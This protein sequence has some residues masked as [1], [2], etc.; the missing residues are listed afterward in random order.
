MRV[1]IVASGE[2]YQQAAAFSA[3]TYLTKSPNAEVSVLVPEE[4]PISN[5]LNQCSE[6]NH[7]DLERFPFRQIS[8]RKFTSQLKCQAFVHALSTAFKGELLAFVDADTCCLKEIRVPR[9]AAQR[10]KDGS[11]AMVPDIK[12]RHF[13]CPNDPWYLAENERRA[14][15]NSGV[16]LATAASLPLFRR[17]RSLSEQSRFLHGPFND[18]KVINFALG[19]YFRDR[20]VMLE[21]KYNFIGPPFSTA[22]IIA[23]FAGGAG[24]L[25]E[26]RRKFLHESFCAH[27]I[28]GKNPDKQKKRGSGV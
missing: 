1:V 6:K 10:L 21:K 16:I 9:K 18:Q 23:H 7:F 27:A 24:Y 28:N 3:R 22:T 5:E 12:D 2:A 13:T 11:I 25:G 17:F 14:Y 8:E 19:K 26:Q 15:V 20:L 4:E